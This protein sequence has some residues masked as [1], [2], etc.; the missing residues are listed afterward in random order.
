M[1]LHRCFFHSRK[2]VIGS[3]REGAPRSGGGECARMKNIKLKLHAGSLRHGVAVPP[4]SRREAG[5]WMRDYCT[6][7][8]FVNRP[9]GNARL[10]MPTRFVGDGALD[11]PHRLP[12]GEGGP[13][14]G[15]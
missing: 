8:R 12:L 2:P 3:L 6:N 15:G 10:Y 7:G 5:E 11:V 4:P 1:H 13:H 14:R 9:Y